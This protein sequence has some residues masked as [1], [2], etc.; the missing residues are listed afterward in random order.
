M[1]IRVEVDVADSIDDCDS[2]WRVR[3]PA[4]NQIRNVKENYVMSLKDVP[5]NCRQRLAAEG[6]VIAKSN[7]AVCGQFSPN[8]KECNA[9]IAGPVD[10]TFVVEMVDSV[11]PLSPS[12]V[13][14]RAKQNHKIPDFV[15]EIVNEMLVLNLRNNSMVTIP[16]D[17]IVSAIMATNKVENRNEIFE[18]KMLDFEDVFSNN[19]WNVT[20]Y[21]SLGEPSYFTFTVKY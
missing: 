21:K 6:K 9:K 5:E 13:R 2:S 19:G 20:H 16:Q 7:C 1:I 15:I 3:I 18:K 14:A 11:K 8:W 10:P 17:D 4:S 12:E